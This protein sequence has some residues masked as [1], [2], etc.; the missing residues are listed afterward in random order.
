M[1]PKSILSTPPRTARPT[2]N[3]PAL[4]DEASYIAMLDLKERIE[5]AGHRFDLRR[6]DSHE[7]Y[8]TLLE[9][10][11]NAAIFSQWY[12]CKQTIYWCPLDSIKAWEQ[13]PNLVKMGLEKGFLLPPPPIMAGTDWDIEHR[14]DGLHAVA[15][16]LMY[17]T[18]ENSM[19]A[20]QFL[21]R[22]PMVTKSSTKRATKAQDDD[23][24]QTPSLRPLPTD[25][26][27]P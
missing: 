25:E 16:D 4:P 27:K 10:T 18:I 24:T 2:I 9:V 11:D 5:A 21:E 1:Y 12:N 23:G 8:L 19:A 22:F 14:P 13:N 3:L 17:G 7:L 15:T 6:I 26:F 20:D